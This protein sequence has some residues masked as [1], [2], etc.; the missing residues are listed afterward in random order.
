MERVLILVHFPYF[1]VDVIRIHTSY[2]YAHLHI[3][4]NSESD[5]PI[6]P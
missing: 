4:F 2:L 5:S 3:Y 1:M 6:S